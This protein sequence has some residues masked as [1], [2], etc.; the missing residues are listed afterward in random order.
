M[1]I[2]YQIGEPEAKIRFKVEDFAKPL[3]EKLKAAEKV[4]IKDKTVEASILEGDEEEA[5]LLESLK[6]LKNQKAKN[7]NHKRKHG[8][9]GDAVA[10]K[11][12]NAIDPVL[13]LFLFFSILDCKP[14][15]TDH[16]EAWTKLSMRRYACRDLRSIFLKKK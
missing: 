12:S 3:V 11:D 9:Q 15:L 5:F 16:A 4:E 13:V 6:D 2:T 14:R 1:G 8:G 7:K 10:A